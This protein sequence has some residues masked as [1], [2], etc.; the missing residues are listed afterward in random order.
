MTAQ[1][2]EAL[3][4]L[5]ELGTV[6][7]IRE[8]AGAAGSGVAP[9]V[10]SHIHLPPNFSAFESVEQAVGLAQEQGVGVLGV[11]NYYDYD[12]YNDFA[13]LARR[14]G[15]FPLYGLEIIAL[16]PD[17]AERGIKMNDPGN[18]GKPGL[19]IHCSL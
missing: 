5:K 4:T 19:P 14:A 11:S 3:M 1:T 2:L 10:N 17:L 13:V 7:A 15:I 12:V 16:D 8:K 18:P 9:R 6:A